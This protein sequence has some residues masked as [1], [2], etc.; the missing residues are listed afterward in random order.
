MIC[1]KL[2]EDDSFFLHS[3]CFKCD[4]ILFGN[5]GCLSSSKCNIKNN[6][7]NCSECK[8]AIFNHHKFVHLAQC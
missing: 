4:D 2:C 6:Q 3:S 8:K 5:P 1:S 7:L